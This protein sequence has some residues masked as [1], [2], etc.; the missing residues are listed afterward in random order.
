MKLLLHALGLGMLAVPSMALAQGKAHQHGVLAL[1]IAVE[2]RKLT[3][4]MQSPLD[5]FV[6]FERAPRNDAERQRV[7]A[8]LAKL[9]AVQA[10][11]VIDPAAQCRLSNVTIGSAVLGLGAA[12]PASASASAKDQHADID[13]SVEFECQDA[14]RAAFIDIG[15]FD[16]FAATKRI[17]VQVATPKGQLKRTLTRPARRVA[18]SR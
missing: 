17:E 2:A 14:A 4:Q 6:G 11:F 12:Q 3:L 7:E 18:L 15:L 9:R 8:A 1:D 13:A 16:A 10:L 5:N